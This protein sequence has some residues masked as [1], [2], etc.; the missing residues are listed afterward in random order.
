MEKAS[1][2][3]IGAGVVGLAI[4]SRLGETR[5]PR[6]I[7]VVERHDGFGRETSSRNS[8]VIHAGFYYP[9]DSLKAKLCVEGNRTMYELCRRNEIPH[10][11]TGKIV[12]ANTPW[13]SDKLHALYEQGRKNGVTG[14]ELLSGEEV[15]NLEPSVVAE[16]G[17]LSPSTGIVDTHSLMKYFES[18]AQS[19]GVTIGY[20]CG[21][22]GIERAG[23]EYIVRVLDADNEEMEIRAAVVINCAGLRSG[24]VAAMAGID[25]GAAAY[26]IHPCKGEYF[27]VS[28]RHRGRLSRL[29]YPAPTSISLGVHAVLKLDGSLKLGP[30]A[31][32]VASDEDYGVDPSHRK[33]FHDAARVYLPFLD[34]SDLQ[35]D[36]AGIRPKRQSKDEAF[37]DF[38]IREEGDRGLPNLI[39]LV[40]IESPGLTAAPAIADHVC[41]IVD[42]L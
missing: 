14:L 16:L 10:K 27:S 41:G 31:F 1:I 32:Y 23:Q 39:N 6:D 2:T 38:I 30:N 36:M 28:N 13:E 26:T 8:E 18:R 29:V 35:P 22:T 42:A 7:V 40:G 21:V 17:L 5:S 9:Q 3:I 4:A 19:F 37:R 12:I 34:M 33:E 24:A 15:R 25:T 11:K 20:N